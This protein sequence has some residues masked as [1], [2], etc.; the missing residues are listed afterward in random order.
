MTEAH[1]PDSDRKTYYVSVGAGQVL[2]DK[3]AAPFE[4]VIRANEEEL[5][6]LQELFEETS[7]TDEAGAFTLEGSPM[8]SDSPE[9]AT[10]DGLIH[11]V[12]ELLYELG[13][14]ETKRH[15]ESMGILH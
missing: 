12:Y 14:D 11:S 2:E 10:Y 8:V 15:I 4:L 7:S 13:T 5:N 1:V 9:D 3:E 6:Q